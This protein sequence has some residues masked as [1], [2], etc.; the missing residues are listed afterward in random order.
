VRAWEVRADAL[1]LHDVDPVE[2]GEGQTLVRVSHTGLCGSDRPKLLDPARYALPEPWRPGH[3]IV[4]FRADGRAV[5]VDPLLP[6]GVCPGC[7]AG[8]THLCPF[9]LRVGW[10]LPGGFAEQVAVP[11]DNVRLLPAGASLPSMSLAD[12]AAVAVHG[13]RC[14]GTATGSRLA[15]IGAGPV[16]LL[17]ALYAG[18]SG[19]RVVVFHRAGDG[20]AGALA[21]AMPA[22]FDSSVGTVTRDRFDVVV[23][24][25]AGG[26]GAPLG[27]ALQ[28]VRD[29]GTVVVQNAYAPDVRLATPVRDVFRR[30]IR[31]V[32]SFSHCRRPPGDLTLAFD[33]L[34]G[35]PEPIAALVR[36][37]RL[38]DLPNVLHDRQHRHVRTVLAVSG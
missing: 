26:D 1:G 19:W 12:P 9:L 25:A 30:S 33:L 21:A 31:L 8:D 27:L 32:G 2:P 11:A 36:T 14:V 3:E 23:D 35:Q 22:E 13:L 34:R 29:G 18:V 38:S 5:A 20:V 4:G 15:V 6:C 24:A 16:G 7:V 10:D 17:T 37:A 28:L